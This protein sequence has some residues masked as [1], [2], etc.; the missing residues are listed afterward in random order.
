MGQT[1]DF[2]IL[3]ETVI[4]SLKQVEVTKSGDSSYTTPGVTKL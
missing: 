3:I 2:L 4:T 1:F